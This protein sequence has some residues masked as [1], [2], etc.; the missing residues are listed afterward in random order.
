[1]ATSTGQSTG[2]TIVGDRPKPIHDLYHLWLRTT[3]PRA[4]LLIAVWY[5]IVNA[6]FVACRTGAVYRN[7]SRKAR[8]SPSIASNPVSLSRRAGDRLVTNAER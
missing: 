8:Q 1:M 3:W 2:V 6:L 4:I 7:R 5:L